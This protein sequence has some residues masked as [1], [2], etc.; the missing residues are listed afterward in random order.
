MISPYLKQPLR[1]LEQAL[2]DR[3]PAG[4]QKRAP[5]APAGPGEGQMDPAERFVQLLSN[6]QGAA[7]DDPAPPG[8]RRAA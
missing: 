4:S 3:G 6:G 5:A 1:T 8:G 2:Q 7:A